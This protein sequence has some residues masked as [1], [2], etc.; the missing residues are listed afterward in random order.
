MEYE[1]ETNNKFERVRVH[2]VRKHYQ[3]LPAPSCV[4][5]R[6]QLKKNY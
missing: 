3:D 2:E 5:S 6:L 4:R 1:S